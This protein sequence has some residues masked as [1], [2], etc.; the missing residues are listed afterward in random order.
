MDR[1]HLFMLVIIFV[2]LQLNAQQHPL[3]RCNYQ[4]NH[5]EFNKSLYQP[6]QIIAGSMLIS[7][8]T[9]TEIMAPTQSMEQNQRMAASMFATTVAIYFVFR[10]INHHKL[11][12]KHR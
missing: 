9:V 11:R 7:T 5:K 1:K 4:L 8:F 6:Q 2:S 10:A 3:P 12:H